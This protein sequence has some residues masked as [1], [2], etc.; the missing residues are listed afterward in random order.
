VLIEV[1]HPAQPLPS[2]GL[3]NAIQGLQNFLVEHPVLTRR[4]KFAAWF[5]AVTAIS[6][7]WFNR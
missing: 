1:R 4:T 7:C 6:F 2:I 5:V 3:V